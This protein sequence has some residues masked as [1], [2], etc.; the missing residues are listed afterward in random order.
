MMKKFISVLLS[1][2]FFGNV[3]ITTVQAEIKIYEGVG[4]FLLTNENL[5][6]AKNKAK[7][8][9]IR[10]ISEEIF[11]KIQSSSELKDIS[12]VHD[13][14]IA[15]SESLINITEVKYQLGLT[16]DDKQVIKAFVTAEVDT[17]EVEKIIKKF[18]EE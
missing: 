15:M 11:I 13:E 8:K 17:E 1:I 5:D 10:C 16:K 7:L 2:F 6:Y 14:I 4:E 9:G 3:F 18:K 12:Q